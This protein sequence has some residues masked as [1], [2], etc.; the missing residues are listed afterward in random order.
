MR[1]QFVSLLLVVVVLASSYVLLGSV[2]PLSTVTK[3]LTSTYTTSLTK[4][5]TVST[6]YTTYERTQTFDEL[7]GPDLT[8]FT[9]FVGGS[10]CRNVVRDFKAGDTIS[11]HGSRDASVRIEDARGKVLQT[12]EFYGNYNYNTFVIER[13]GTY[14]IIWCWYWN[15]FLMLPYL[16]SKARIFA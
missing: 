13:D 14:Q 9:P 1:K 7:F 4:S 8:N 10:Q 11:V 12:Y 3:T 5:T 15:A 16:S 6:V 2:N